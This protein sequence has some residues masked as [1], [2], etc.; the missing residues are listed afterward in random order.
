MI[1]DALRQFLT[2]GAGSIAQSALGFILLP[3]YLRFFEPAEYG[4]IS[5]LLV[6]ISLIT[7]FANSTTSAGT[8]R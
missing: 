2:Y 3:I 7:L 6:G 4:V 5:L 8:S 1:K